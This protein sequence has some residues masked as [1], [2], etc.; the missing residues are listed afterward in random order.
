MR[1]VVWAC[2]I[3]PDETMKAAA[4]TARRQFFIIRFPL[5]RM[6][7][8][9]DC[10]VDTNPMTGRTFRAFHLS[11][12]VVASWLPGCG[13]DAGLDDG[14]IGHPARI[15]ARR[16]ELAE[17]GPMHAAD[18]LQPF[19][20]SERIGMIVDAQIERGPF[21]AVMDQ[22]RGGLLAALV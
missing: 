20:L 5:T 22:E 9:C 21:L 7:L 15:D 11:S 3:A 19:E 18:L 14:A 4:S 13:G 10:T 8:L 6:L 2:A 12:C 16:H 17:R 1:S